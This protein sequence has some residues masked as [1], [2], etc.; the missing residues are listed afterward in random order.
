MKQLAWTP[1]LL[2]G[3]VPG[4]GDAAEFLAVSVEDK[5]YDATLALLYLLRVD[6]LP[7]DEGTQRR[8]DAEG[9]SPA[10]VVF[11]RS[12]PECETVQAGVVQR[13]PQRDRLVFQRR[14]IR[15]AP[16]LDGVAKIITGERIGGLE[17]I[18]RKTRGVQ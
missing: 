6:E 3:D 16:E 17:A 9:E 13:E 10:I 11:G 5:R 4:A 14:H 1:R 12:V 2:A 8:Q 7:L 18:Q 15:L